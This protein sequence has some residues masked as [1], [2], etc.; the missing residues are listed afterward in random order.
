[1]FVSLIFCVQNAVIHGSVVSSLFPTTAF[2]T[3]KIRGFL[4]N[5]PETPITANFEM[6]HTI[7]HEAFCWIIMRRTCAGV[8]AGSNAALLH[9]K[10]AIVAKGDWNHTSCM[11][12]PARSAHLGLCLYFCVCMFSFVC[13]YGICMHVRMYAMH[14]K[15]RHVWHVCM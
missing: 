11:K 10:I 7:H 6:S 4:T 14:V 9:S 3:Q 12:A 5:F 15:F 13:V 1:M 8:L 2:C